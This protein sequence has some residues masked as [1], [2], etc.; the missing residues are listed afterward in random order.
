M[1]STQS[2]DPVIILLTISLAFAGSYASIFVYKQ[3]RS[4]FLSPQYSNT[5]YLT[6]AGLCSKINRPMI[7]SPTVLLAVMALTLGGIVVWSTHF[8]GLGAMKL[9]DDDGNIV[10][11]YYRLDLTIASLIIV[12]ITSEISV[13]SASRDKRY[14]L[15]KVDAVESLMNKLRQMSIRGIRKNLEHKNVL[16]MKSLFKNMTSIILSGAIAASGACL[17]HYVGMMSI[18]FEGDVH[19]DVGIVIASAI[20]AFIAFTSTFWILFRVISLFPDKEILH[21]GG[22]LWISLSFNAVH[23]VGCEATI[24]IGDESQVIDSKYY[25]INYSKGFYGVLFAATALLVTVFII[26]VTDMHLWSHNSNEIFR[27]LDTYLSEFDDDAKTM[28]VSESYGFVELYLSLRKADDKY[29]EKFRHK[30]RLATAWR[31]SNASLLY[32]KKPLAIDTSAPSSP[33][34]RGEVFMSG[35]SLREFPSSPPKTSVVD[36]LLR[37]SRDKQSFD[38]P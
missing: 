36:S 9:L 10:D 4:S 11:V 24:F 31:R 14:M 8:I 27:E 19:Y 38:F 23:Y 18:V 28:S 29:V 12:I 33:L 21:C 37:D 20:L 35:R 3:F 7:L 34:N 15:D 32:T 22:A 16:Y 2:Y 1:R 30:R 5:H 13:F 17:M 6:F 26:C 25:L